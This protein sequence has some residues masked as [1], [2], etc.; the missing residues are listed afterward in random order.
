MIAK[1][2]PPSGVQSFSPLTPK[3]LYAAELLSLLDEKSC[4]LLTSRD[5]V[6]ASKRG[7]S[8]SVRWL[9][10]LF[11][12]FAKARSAVGIG[13]YTK[14]Q[15]VMVNQLYAVY[16]ELG[17]V[18]TSLDVREASKEG[19]CFSVRHIGL[20]FGSFNSYIAAAGFPIWRIRRKTKERPSVQRRKLSGD[21]AI[22]DLQFLT[23]FLERK[24]TGAEVGTLN[25]LGACR[26]VR[27]YKRVLN[28][29]TFEEAL[30]LAACWEEDDVEWIKLQGRPFI[31]VRE[32]QEIFGITVSMTE[33]RI[34]EGLWIV[35]SLQHSAKGGRTGTQRLFGVRT[36]FDFWKKEQGKYYPLGVVAKNLKERRM[37]W[38]GDL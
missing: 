11:G 24:F 4:R 15:R 23:W 7:E 27:T 19:K 35:E 21:E 28:V 20:T 10:H 36:I 34:R 29:S 26:S 16:H 1:H 5:V 30:K 8:Y 3:Q 9:T 33:R 17:R 12:S 32:I 25:R 6:Q 31:T 37:F 14:R 38:K 22:A 18:P 13:V 2:A